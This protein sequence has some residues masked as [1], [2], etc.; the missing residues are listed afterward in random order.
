MMRFGERK[1]VS[2][3]RDVIF[4]FC[5]FEDFGA[6]FERSDQAGECARGDFAHESLQF[7]ER[8]G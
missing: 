4:A 3:D 6:G 5:G 8:R 2:A 7:G 1:V